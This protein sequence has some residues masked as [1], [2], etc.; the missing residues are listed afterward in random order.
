MVKFYCSSPSV[1]R[2]GELVINALL[3]TA[4]IHHNL[5][6][7]GL[8]CDSNLIIETASA[9]DS[10]QIACLIGYGATAVYPIWVMTLS[11]I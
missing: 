9:R 7:K 3:A 1:C 11:S 6:E 2:K 10:H 5:N 4:A 8:R